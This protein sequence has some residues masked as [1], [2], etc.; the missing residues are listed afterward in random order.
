MQRWECRFSGSFQIHSLDLLDANIL[1]I[2]MVK[3]SREPE[4]PVKCA[5]ARASDLRVHFKVNSVTVISNTVVSSC[6]FHPNALY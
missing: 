2:G 4:N 5:K 6:D 3:Y 1:I